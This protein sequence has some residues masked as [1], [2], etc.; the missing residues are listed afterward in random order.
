MLWYIQSNRVI[1]CEADSEYK[2][3]A[4]WQCAIDGVLGMPEPL[5]SSFI[6]KAQQTL[7]L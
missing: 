3:T 2:K 4:V 1:I 7:Q 6:N 5:E